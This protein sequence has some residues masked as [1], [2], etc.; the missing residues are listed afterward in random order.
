MSIS[1]ELVTHKVCKRCQERLPLTKNFVFF[2]SSNVY[3]TYCHTCN[4]LR[5]KEWKIKNQEKLAN[6]L[7][8]YNT[9]E[10]GYIKNAVGRLFKPS[11]ADTLS[12]NIAHGKSWNSVGKA[13]NFTKEEFWA[14]LMLYVSNMKERFPHTDGR[15][16][17][18]CFTP[19]T[20]IRSKPNKLKL[21][22]GDKSA[23]GKTV[24][25]RAWTNFSIDRYDNNKS[26]EIGNIVFCCSRCNS[27][28]N[29]STKG[30]WKRFLEVEQELKDEHDQVE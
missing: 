23:G 3:N 29:A 13:P 7:Q 2:P 27:I 22:M 1:E 18:Y 19:W 8:K 24:R 30:M 10:Q 11:S 20:Y 6:T 4:N 26:Y 9:S 17:R 5:T 15:I 25:K 14:E 16:C 12:K 21:G 28:K